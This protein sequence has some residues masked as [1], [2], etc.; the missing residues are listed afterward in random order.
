[1]FFTQCYNNAFQYLQRLTAM[2]CMYLYP[3]ARVCSQTPICS[4][5]P[6][7]GEAGGGEAE[8]AGRA[9]VPGPSEGRVADGRVCPGRGEKVPEPAGP[10]P[11]ETREAAG[12]QGSAPVLPRPGRRNCE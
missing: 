11:T 10:P 3:F 8:G 12:L 9:A 5:S 4:L 7:D 2:Y 1:M 6:G